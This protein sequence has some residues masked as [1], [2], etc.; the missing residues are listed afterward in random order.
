MLYRATL[1]APSAGVRRGIDRLLEE[2][3]RGHVGLGE[4][5]PAVDICETGQELAFEVE[6]PGL[7]LENVEVIV[8]NGVLTVR[9]ERDGKW[10]EEEGQGTG[11]EERYYLVE[12]SYGAFSRSFQLPPGV[13]EA[14]I[15]ADFDRGV[16]R[17]HVPK[18]ALSPPRRVGITAGA[19]A[20]RPTA[21]AIGPGKS[22]HGSAKL[23][24]GAHQ[25]K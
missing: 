14:S 16:L 12:R 25:P 1:T 22:R 13:D 15:Q 10:T 7:A 18:T 21:Q 11:D 19:S 5:T 3:F 23:T 20:R 8:E 2:I 6:L 4:W 9:G 24:A 17:V